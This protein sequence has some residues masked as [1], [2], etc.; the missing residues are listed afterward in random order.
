MA[1]NEDEASADHP[2]KLKLYKK[3]PVVKQT[4]DENEFNS[5][6]VEN[7]DLQ[8]P[9]TV[10]EY[11]Y[12]IEAFNLGFRVRNFFPAARDCT[13]SLRI[14]LND[15]NS[16]VINS[17]VEKF[18]AETYDFGRNYTKLVS[19]QFAFSYLFCHMTSVDVYDY[20]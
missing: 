11:F 2:K 14:F 9:R 16:T 20:V 5:T 1:F 6:E 15:L 19:N 8:N 10:D 13:K 3:R 7:Y 17:T 4:I 18:T 12:L